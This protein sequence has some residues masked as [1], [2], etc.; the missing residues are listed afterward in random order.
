MP[1]CTHWHHNWVAN[2]VVRRLWSLPAGG[3]G[4]EK[5]GDGPSSQAPC[6]SDDL[7][8]ASRNQQ[9]PR[10]TRQQGGAAAA[11][12]PHQ[13]SVRLQGQLA[14]EM[15]NQPPSIAAE[16]AH[17]AAG[18][19]EGEGLHTGR[20][21]AQSPQL[22]ITCS[23]ERTEAELDSLGGE[24]D[25]PSSQR[26]GGF[27]SLRGMRT[28]GTSL[29]ASFERSGSPAAFPEELRTGTSA[30]QHPESAR[31][32]PPVHSETV[33]MASC[34]P[35]THLGRFASRWPLLLYRPDQRLI[36]PQ[37]LRCR[38]CARPHC[39]CTPWAARALP[40]CSAAVETGG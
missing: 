32:P 40:L 20:K 29:V 31:P 22:H 25:P 14:A 23:L 6:Q 24:S 35:V 3:P 37:G 11:A 17:G 10:A 33:W 7:P 21:Q 8:R 15:G 13:A 28:R 1:I 4:R 18:E 36:C 26:S 12:P 27:P 39:F 2:R 19:D 30:G 38:R 9:Q 34:R 16:P 5:K